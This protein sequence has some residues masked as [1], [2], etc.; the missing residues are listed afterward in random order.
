M[1]TRTISH[2]NILEVI[3]EGGMGIVYKA[4]DLHLESGKAAKHEDITHQQR[5]KREA[6][7]QVQTRAFP[8]DR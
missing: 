4:R 2:Y 3:G 1:I 7:G 8:Q 5:G 6:E